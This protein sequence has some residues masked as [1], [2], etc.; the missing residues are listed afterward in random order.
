[1]SST[2]TSHSRRIA[3]DHFEPEENLDPQAQRRLR[4]QL[5]QIDYTAFACNREVMKAMIGKVDFD[6]MQRLALKTAQARGRW[7]AKAL[8]LSDGGA[9]PGAEDVAELGRLRDAFHELG[10]AYEAVRRLVERGYVTFEGG[11]KPG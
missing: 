7:A 8:S 6:R 11:P 10:E 9:E 1:M 5:E 4:G 2:V 3:L